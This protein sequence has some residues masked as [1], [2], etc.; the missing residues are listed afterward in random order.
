MLDVYGRGWHRS[1]V[2]WRRGGRHRASRVLH[3][4]RGP[5]MLHGCGLG[6]SWHSLWRALI[7]AIARVL[8]ESTALRLCWLLRLLIW[9]LLLRSLGLLLALWLV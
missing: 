4:R 9:R 1:L 2:A 6:L 8:A 3:F 5:P 7:M